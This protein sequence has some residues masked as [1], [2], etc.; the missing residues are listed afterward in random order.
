MSHTSLGCLFRCFLLCNAVVTS[1]SI[2]NRKNCEQHHRTEHPK[3]K[4]LHYHTPFTFSREKLLAKGNEHPAS[5]LI[6]QTTFDLDRPLGS[7]SYE[8]L[9]TSI[10]RQRLLD[11]LLLLQRIATC[12]MRPLRMRRL[13]LTHSLSSAAKIACSD[14][15]RWNRNRLQ[16]TTLHRCCKYD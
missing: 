9:S 1:R 8:S 14:G 3:C 13:L 16:N 15:I 12:I 11:Y 7:P 10:R 5:L 2:R 4:P 6:L